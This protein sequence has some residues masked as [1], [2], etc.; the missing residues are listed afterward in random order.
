MTEIRSNWQR[1]SGVE[2]KPGNQGTALSFSLSTSRMKF[3]EGFSMDPSLEADTR[4]GSRATGGKGL[5][6]SLPLPSLTPP[7]TCQAHRCVFLATVLFLG[8]EG[9]TVC[10]GSATF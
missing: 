1:I 6:K 8:R 5:R 3:L 4:K 7:T 9:G 2:S 10:V